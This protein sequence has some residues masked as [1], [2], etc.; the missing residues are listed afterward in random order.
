MGIKTASPSK[1]GGPAGTFS[2]T[3]RAEAAR[4]KR[5]HAPISPVAS[6]PYLTLVIARLLNR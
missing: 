1:T 5:N 6:Y 3:F 2:N 4:D